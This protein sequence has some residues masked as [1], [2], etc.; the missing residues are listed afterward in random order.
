MGLTPSKQILHPRKAR[1]RISGAP[2]ASGRAPLQSA[3]PTV[4]APVQRLL[5]QARPGMQNMDEVRNTAGAQREP[6]RIPKRA[7]YTPPHPLT[8]ASPAEPTQE[9]RAGALPKPVKTCL[10]YTSDAADE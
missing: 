10:L 7:S 3:P 4:E 6:P 9:V 2:T 1:Q 8:A 5:T